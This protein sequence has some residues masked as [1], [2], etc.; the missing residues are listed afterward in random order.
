LSASVSTV[1]LGILE[2]LGEHL[3]QFY[4]SFDDYF[5]Q[6]GQVSHE[7]SADLF[8]DHLQGVDERQIAVEAH[9]A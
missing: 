8:E 1:C 5:G 6:R 7:E 2:L 9:A 3:G 4:Y